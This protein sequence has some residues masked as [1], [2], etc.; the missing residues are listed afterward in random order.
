MNNEPPQ[1]VDAQV[2]GRAD[3]GVASSEDRIRNRCALVA[4]IL[5]LAAA[6]VLSVLYLLVLF[7][8]MFGDGGGQI[9]TDA[10]KSLR[11]ITLVVGFASA[12]LPVVATRR[13]LRWFGVVV[14][15]LYLLLLVL[16]YK[17]P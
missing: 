9:D 8:P 6:P 17:W 3:G 1:I 10:V 15:C 4:S 16:M 13:W 12:W 2:G 14:F 11:S 5:A 7:G